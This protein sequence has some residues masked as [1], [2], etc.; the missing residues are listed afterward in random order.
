M[1]CTEIIMNFQNPGLW[2]YLFEKNAKNYSIRGR[3]KYYI[4]HGEAPVFLGPKRQERI[5][6]RKNKRQKMVSSG[7]EMNFRIPTFRAVMLVAW[8]DARRCVGTIRSI[9]KKI[10]LFYDCRK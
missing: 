6:N 10:F 4:S 3:G 2:S 9:H 8:H 5:Y 1:F 7:N